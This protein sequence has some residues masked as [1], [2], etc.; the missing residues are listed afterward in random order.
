MI[1][2]MQAQ[3]FERKYFILERQVP[4]IREFVSGY[5]TL[6]EFREGL[7]ENCYS[8]HSIYLDS[9]QLTTYWATVHC[10]KLRFKLRARYYSDDPASPIFFD[11]KRRENECVL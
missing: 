5:L 1:D 8:V 3:R 10:E 2:R 7:P 11:I 9:D 4:S 6:D